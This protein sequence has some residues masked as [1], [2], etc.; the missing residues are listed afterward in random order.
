MKGIK[1]RSQTNAHNVLI[2]TSGKS[3]F[4]PGGKKPVRMTME[5]E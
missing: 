2:I 1:N 3:F 5:V 4:Q